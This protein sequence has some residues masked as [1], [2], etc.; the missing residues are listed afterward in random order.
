MGKRWELREDKVEK[1]EQPPLQC[2]IGAPA[3]LPDLFVTVFF[4]FFF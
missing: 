4:F 2:E 1:E 3:S